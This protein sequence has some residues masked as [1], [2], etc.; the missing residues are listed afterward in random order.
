[1]PTYEFL[2]PFA[3]VDASGSPLSPQAGLAQTGGLLTITVGVPGEVRSLF[4]REGRPIPAP[5]VGYALLDTGAALTSI[6]ERVCKG[7]GLVPSGQ[8]LLGHAGGQGMHQCYPVEITLPLLGMPPLVSHS[9]VS[10]NLSSGPHP[11]IALIGRDFLGLMR[12]VYNGPQGRIEIS[13]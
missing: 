12:V 7:L 4:E 1:M 5:V 8:V 3:P 2:T 11:I 6:D 13:I 9:A 10:V